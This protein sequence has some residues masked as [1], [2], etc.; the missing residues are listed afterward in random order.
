V[1][2]CAGGGGVPVARGS[3]RLLTGIE[4]VVDKDL[5]A[6]LLARELEADALLL[7]TDVDAI[8]LN[9][10]LPDERRLARATPDEL[11]ALALPPGSMGPKAQ[12]AARFVALTGGTAAIGRL[13][14]APALVAGRAGTTVRASIS[15]QEEPCSTR[16]SS[17]STAPRAAATR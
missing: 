11:R 7:L 1:V 16:S 3:D 13:E 9:H 4:A 17:A 8:H 5:T 15:T 2:I 10:G 12:A 6:A 14:D